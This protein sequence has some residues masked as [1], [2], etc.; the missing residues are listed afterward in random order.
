MELEITIRFSERQAILTIR[1]GA[2]HGWFSEE[3]LRVLA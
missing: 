2:I 1:S 3:C